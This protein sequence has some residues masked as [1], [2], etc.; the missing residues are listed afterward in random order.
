M[1][2]ICLRNGLL[3]SYGS[4]GKVEKKRSTGQSKVVDD[5][6]RLLEGEGQSL[7]KGEKI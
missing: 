3:R 2:K 5:S 6:G 1:P 7:W 4:L